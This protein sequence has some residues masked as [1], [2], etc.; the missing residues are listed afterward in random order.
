MTKTVSPEALELIRRM[1]Q[2]ELDESV[3][4]KNIASFAGGKENRRTLLRLAKEELA[5]CRIWQQYTGEELKPNKG[6]IL[7][8]TLI[9]RVLGFTFAVKLMERAR[10]TP[11]RHTPG[12]RKRWRKAHTSGSRRR[13]TSRRSLPCWTRSGCNMWAAWSWASTMPWWS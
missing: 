6:K 2:S 13:S 11:R 10:A 8:Y 1:Q 5:H 12:W 9:A 4:Y 3:I 7:F